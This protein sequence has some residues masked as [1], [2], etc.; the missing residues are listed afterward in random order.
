[1]AGFA[2]TL[3][4]QTLGLQMAPVVVLILYPISLTINPLLTATA[5]IAATGTVLLTVSRPTAQP[6]SGVLSV[7]KGHPATQPPVPVQAPSHPAIQPPSHLL[8]DVAIFLISLAAYIATLSP[9]LLPADS[10]EFQLVAPTLGIAHPPG[11]ALHTL[12]GKLFTLIPVGT[13]AYR[14]NL[15][16][17]VL[18]AATLM[19]VNRTTRRLTSSAA[20][21]LVAVAALAGATTF[22]AQATTANIRMPT[23][24]FT[25]LVL[26]LLVRFGAARRDGDLVVLAF[27]AGLGLTHHGSLMFVMLPAAL[28]VVWVQPAVLRNGRLLARCVAALTLA[29]LVL[30][31]FPIRGA[32]GAPLNPGG[33]TTLNGFLNHVLARGFRGDVLAFTHRQV[34]LDRLPVLLNIL[35]IQ[36]DWPLLLLAALGL[37]TPLL[38]YPIPN[39]QYPISKQAWLLLTLVSLL[40]AGAAI[41]YRAP[42]TVE[43]LMPAYVALAV[44]IGMGAADLARLLP[45]RA[46]QAM[47][48]S[49]ALLFG[50][51]NA[52]RIAPSYR[53]LSRQSDTRQVVQPI[54]RDAP[55][56]ATLLSNWHWATAFWYL[57]SVEGLRPDVDVEYIAPAGAEPYPETWRRRLAESLDGRPVLVTNRYQTYADLPARLVPFHDAFLATTAP[58]RVPTNA[59]RLDADFERTIRLEAYTLSNIQLKPGEDLTVRLWWKPQVDAQ[60]DYSVFVHLVNAEGRP[61]GQA[62]VRYPASRLTQG[63]LVEDA[64]SVAILPTVPPGEYGVIAGFYYTPPQGGFQRLTT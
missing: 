15:L 2:L 62:D 31:Y 61:V 47:A 23:A 8:P 58:T 60:H 59:T 44:L 53:L 33:L 28:Y 45:W 18:A 32:A 1:M 35:T 24:F 22:W 49:I 39:I 52:W 43:Y 57:Q 17:A 54:L 36:F 42:Q 51:G 41:T 6:S 20:A 56:N 10:G 55:A 12:V 16:S 64:Y 25:A 38:Q 21:G 11:Y 14:L 3:I 34:L 19:L 4:A 5:F 7:S 27:V 30:L 13:P 29:L 48:L 9:G 37:L 50:L 26:W 63:A 46:L 40:V